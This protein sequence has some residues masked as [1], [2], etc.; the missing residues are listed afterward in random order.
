MRKPIT[1]TLLLFVP[2]VLLGLA[3]VSQAQLVLYDDFNV[4]PIN[5]AR[6]SGSEA[7]GGPLAPDT[8]TARKIAKGE[9][10]ITLTTW[11]RTDSDTGNNGLPSSRLSVTNPTPI[12]IFQVDVTVKSAK[13][14][15]CAANTTSSR[16]RAQING[17]YFND[18]T[19]PGAGDRTG[20]IVANFQLHRD[21]ING[22]KIQANVNRCTNASCSTF[23]QVA[24]I[25]TATWVQG[26]ASTLNIQWDK[27]NKRFIF[28]LNPG[29]SQEQQILTY[30]FSDA[31]PAVAP[32][33]QLASQDS[34]ASCQS[35]PRGSATIKGLFDNVMVNP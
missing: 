33:R 1:A 21:S 9:L 8:E 23:T 34:A 2:L 28:T 12:T 4:K 3:G 11:G 16:A 14:V 19:S 26:V 13:V 7:S 29:G 15:G 27:P 6:W 10:E 17:G 30:T 22:D 31:N 20:D 18:G 5:P 24:V 32:F 25:F 35:G